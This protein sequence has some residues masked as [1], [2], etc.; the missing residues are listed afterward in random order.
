MVKT[1]FHSRLE[2]LVEEEVQKITEEIIG[3]ISDLSN[4][5]RMVGRIDGLKGAL[6]LCEDIERD[7]DQ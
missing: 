6:R 1:R 3:G 7:L 4:Y 2:V 5:F